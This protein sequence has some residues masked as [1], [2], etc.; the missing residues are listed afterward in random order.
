VKID[1]KTKLIA[2]ARLK[3]GDSPKTVSDDLE[4]SYGQALTLNKKLRAAVEQDNL[5]E[6]FALDKA[7]LKAVFDIAKE[8]LEE[9]ARILTGDIQP[10]QESVKQVSGEIDTLGK[11]DSKLNESALE[12]VR[13]IDLAS[14]ALV[15]CDRSTPDTL[16]VLVDALTRLRKAFFEKDTNVN[17]NQVNGTFEKYLKD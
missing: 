11:L 7:T 16:L 15:F 5:E 2:L 17:I 8:E 6:L 3:L 1:E 13:Q 14:G 10:L 9:P 12:L 4:L